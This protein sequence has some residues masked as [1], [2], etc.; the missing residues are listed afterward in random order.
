MLLGRL[1]K[2]FLVVLKLGS[3]QCRT[4][5]VMDRKARIFTMFRKMV[6][7]FTI[8]NHI[9]KHASWGRTCDDDDEESWDDIN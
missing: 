3:L 5:F 4:I 7:I 6:S 8:I 1:G 9:I 2:I